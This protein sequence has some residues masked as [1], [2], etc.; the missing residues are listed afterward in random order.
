M[1]SSEMKGVGDKRE[2]EQNKTHRKR[3]ERS[4]VDQAPAL[5]CRQSPVQ[6][7]FPAERPVKMKQPHDDQ[8]SGGDNRDQIHFTPLGITSYLGN[9]CACRVSYF[10]QSVCYMPLKMA[11]I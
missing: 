2:S 8:E 3:Q 6:T 11:L 4:G 5:F 7:D 1:N 10:F 9:S